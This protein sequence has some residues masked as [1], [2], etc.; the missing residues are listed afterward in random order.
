MVSGELLVR[1]TAWLSGFLY[2]ATLIG[3]GRSRPVRQLRAF[4]TASWLVFLVHVALAFHVVHAWSHHEAWLHTEKQ[5][6]YGDGIYLNYA[7][8]FVWTV[9]VAWWWMHST[10]YLRRPS[11]VAW[12]VHGFLLFMWVN[13]AIVFPLIK[14]WT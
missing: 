3:W 11:W 13:A 14:W 1:A 7:V 12:S 8:M 9:D 5:S 4:W 2:A 10:S 6:G